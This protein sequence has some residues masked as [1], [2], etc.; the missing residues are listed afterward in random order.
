M[1]KIE[2]SKQSE[3]SSNYKSI[4]TVTKGTYASSIKHSTGKS[5]VRDTLMVTGMDKSK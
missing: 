1:N 5:D 3:N 2:E 4:Y